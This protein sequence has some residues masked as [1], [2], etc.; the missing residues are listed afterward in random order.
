[1]RIAVVGH[2]EHVTLGRVEHVPEAGDIAHLERPRFLAGGGGG[3]AFHQLVR[4]NAE[5]HLFTALG[6]DDGAAE[7]ERV[8]VGTGARLHLAR[9]RGP[10]PRVVV[11]LD[12]HGRRTIVVTSPPLQPTADDPLAWDTLAS[13]DAVYFTGACAR[14]LVFARAAR[15]LVVTAR[16]AHVVAEAAVVPDV[17]VGSASDPRENTSFSAYARPPRA[18]VL[19]QGP[20]PIR[21]E[22]AS[23]L[24]LADA[25]PPVAEVRGDYGAGDSFAA[26]LT[27]FVAAGH[28]VVEA[29]RRAGPFGAAVLSHESP[30]ESAARLG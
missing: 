13:F 24:V 2:V 20:G 16:R 15:A 23:G 6:D 22:T 9:K 30:L 7:V 5:V 19:T 14:S 10:H 18:L 12:A 26:A 27:Y 3:V 1:M 17:L 21:V 4:S 8:L 28:P 11:M 29:A 25:P